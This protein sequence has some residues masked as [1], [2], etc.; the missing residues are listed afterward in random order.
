MNNK[1]LDQK[2]L[3]PERGCVT[4]KPSGKS[5]FFEHWA[6]SA[7]QQCIVT[8]LNYF[9]PNPGQLLLIPIHFLDTKVGDNPFL[10]NP[11]LQIHLGNS[12]ITF[13]PDITTK[14]T[15]REA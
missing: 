9:A 15:K 8:I 7:H 12:S 5:A 11:G 6:P 14:Y 4:V 2:V 1:S 10:G 3:P 13:P